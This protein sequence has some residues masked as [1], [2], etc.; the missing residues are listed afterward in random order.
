MKTIGIL[1]G[2]SWESSADYYR[3]LNEGIKTRLGGLHSAKLILYSVDF[4]PIAQMQKEQNWDEIS[5]ILVEAAEEVQ[6]AGADFLIIASNTIHK[7]APQIQANISIPLLHIADATAH[8]LIQSEVK[9]VGLLGTSF[10][11]EQEFYSQKLQQEYGLNVLIPTNT[12]RDRV[13]SII[14]DELCLGKQTEESKKFFLSVI[15]N[16]ENEGAKAIILGCTEIGGLIKQSDTPVALFDTTDI[17][18]AAAIEMAIK[19]I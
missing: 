3:L 8:K 18:A 10:T 5:V 19:T 15:D 11:M 9:T 1:G 4:A 12:E 7:V 6:S 2:M 14:F 16:L 17:H 13:N